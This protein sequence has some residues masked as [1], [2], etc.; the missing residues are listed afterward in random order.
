VTADLTL[1][2]RAVGTVFDLLGEKENDI[3]Y[4]IGWALA[5]SD[6]FSSSLLKDLLPAVQVPPA[7]LIRLQEG[8]S[9]ASFTDIEIKAEAGKVHVVIEAKRGYQLPGNAQLR[10]YAT[11]TNPAPT[12]LVVIAEAPEDF[13]SGK[14]ATEVAEVPVL[15]RSWRQIEQLA[16]MAA[17]T[18]Q[19]H[20]EKRLL[21]ELSNYL[22]GLMTMQNVDSNMVYVVSLGKQIEKTGMTYRDVVVEYDTYFCPVG[23]SS[24]GWPKEPPNYLGFR[25]DGKLQQVRHVEDYRVAD[26]NYAGFAPLKGKVDWPDE[27]HWVFCWAL[28]SSRRARCGPEI[29]SAHSG[30]GWR[31]ICC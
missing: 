22:K 17:A 7:E 4:A 1:Y 6:R 9:G 19:R 14:L 31:S 18:S 12:M 21:G 30:C 8:I 15:Y 25:F 13:A 5:N 24:S 27:R 16:S 23:G 2:G 26:D 28:R 20:A 10:K 3:T 11:R 29:C